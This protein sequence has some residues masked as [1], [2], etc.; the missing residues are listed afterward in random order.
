MC[1][2]KKKFKS[3]IKMHVLEVDLGFYFSSILFGHFYVIEPH[4][5][6]GISIDVRYIH[7]LAAEYSWSNKTSLVTW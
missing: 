3:Q 4:S 2:R 7:V 1:K 6:G 5:G